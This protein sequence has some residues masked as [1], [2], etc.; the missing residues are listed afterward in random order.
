MRVV[1]L[2]A[3]KACTEI[4]SL[5]VPHTGRHDGEL[6]GNESGGPYDFKRLG[7]VRQPGSFIV[8]HR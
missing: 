3:A 6:M 1:G 5:Y 7:Q 8:L 2:L 4:A